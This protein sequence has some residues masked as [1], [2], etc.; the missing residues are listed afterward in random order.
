MS[1]GPTKTFQ[2]STFQHFNISTFQHFNISTFQHFNISTFQHFNISTFQHFNISTFNIQ[3]PPPHHPSPECGTLF[4][5]KTWD[6]LAQSDSATDNRNWSMYMQV[7][8]TAVALGDLVLPRCTTCRKTRCRSWLSMD[9]KEE[10][11][12]KEEEP[13]TR[14]EGPPR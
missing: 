6:T 3:P 12:D 4:V 7:K 1:V 8:R 5:R 11:E 13:T 9:K 2:H 14:E 10:D